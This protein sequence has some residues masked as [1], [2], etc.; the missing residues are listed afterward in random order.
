MKRFAALALVVLTA[1]GGCATEKARGRPW[2]HQLRFVGVRSV[3]KRDLR[4]KLAIEK[5]S[6]FPLAPKRYLDPL[7]VDMDRERIEAYYRAHGW[8]GARV[9]DATVKPVKGPADHPKAV[10]VTFTVDEGA[11]T[12]TTSV[13]VQ[14]LPDVRG[15]AKLERAFERAIKTGAVFN[16]DQ[17]QTAKSALEDG[18]RALGYAWSKVSGTV[19]VDRD[20]RQAKVIMKVDPGPRARFGTLQVV[21]TRRTSAH[22]VARHA[23]LPKGA[24]FDPAVLE[25]VRGRVYNL[26]VF[27]SVKVD[28]D[29][30]PGDPEVADVTV[31]VQESTFNE[32]RLGLG[33]GLESQR[34]DVHG[35]FIYT[36]HNFLG[37]LRQLRL[38]LEPAYVA[39]PA[40]WNVERSGPALLAEAQ[41]TQPD[42]PWP[43]AAL[44]FTVGYDIGIEYAYQYH[45]PRTSL[46]LSHSLWNQHVR[47]GL[48][49]HF[50][51]L[52]FFNTDPAILQDPAQAGELFGYTNPYRLGWW[53][54][55]VTLDLRDRPLDAHSGFYASASLEEGGAYAGG[56]FQYEKLVPEVRGYVPLGSRVTLAARA[57]FGQIFSQGDL[58]SP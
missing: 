37:R 1:V 42:L 36:R 2:V 9:T 11:P 7:T 19:E 28:Y 49:Y 52:L 51:L 17:Y 39:I 45:G 14:G 55:D 56:A 12:H 46:E 23:A 8:F 25:A 33:I 24:R 58:G 50:Q 10:D 57:Q 4:S 26:G 5:T 53:Q 3:K 40:F 34:T 47:L 54:Q 13:E 21:G 44:T 41:L 6:W 27:S 48:S 38:R 30:Q 16:H 35:S 18:L 29:H 31:T 22:D 43:L 15:A 32:L 20:T